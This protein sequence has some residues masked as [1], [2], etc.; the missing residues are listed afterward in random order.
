MS[1]SISDLGPEEPHG[2]PGEGPSEWR[3]P[4]GKEP[5][6]QLNDN[7]PSAQAEGAWG[8]AGKPVREA[9]RR[10][11]KLVHE[12]MENREGTRRGAYVVDDIDDKDRLLRAV[13][14]D[15]PEPFDPFH[16]DS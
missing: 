11:V 3:G 14:E 5:E 7:D 13:R 10:W 1:D 16:P 8:D 2:D 6:S 12:F 15:R 9:I 4:R